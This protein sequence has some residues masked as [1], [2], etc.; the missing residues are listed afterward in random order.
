MNCPTGEDLSLCLGI[1]L[2]VR[3][4]ISLSLLHLFIFI[5]YFTRDRFAILVNTECFLLKFVAII[6]FTIFLMF[7]KN[8]Y[9][10]I[11]LEFSK[12]ISFIFLLF[13]SKSL[14]DFGYVWN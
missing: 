12:P 11:V 10:A 3:V 5:L 7:I 13:Q 8:D 1:S 4:A 6:I 9:L 14:I 2:I